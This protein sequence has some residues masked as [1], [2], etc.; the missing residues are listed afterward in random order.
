MDFTLEPLPFAEDALEPH[1]GSRTVNIHYHKHH[2]GYL[3]KLD[4]A[5]ENDE[6]RAM[7][8]E[9]IIRTSQGHIFNCAAQ[10]WNHSFYWKSIAP[11]RSTEPGGSLRE[12]IER[13]FGSVAAVKKELHAVLDH[14]INWEFAEDNFGSQGA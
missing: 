6:R 1:I 8:L 7:T 2:K 5:L 9:Q 13:D 11:G 10:V 12:Q 4:K 14:L 3:D